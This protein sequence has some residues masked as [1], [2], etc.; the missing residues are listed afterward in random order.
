MR[1]R[2]DQRADSLARTIRLTEEGLRLRLAFLGLTDRERRE[3]ARL[4]PWAERVADSIAKRFYDFQFGFEPTRRFFERYAQARGMPL[5]E[6]RR[7][8]EQ[9]QADYFREIFRAAQQGYDLAY[10]QQRLRIGVRHNLIDLPMKWYLGSYGRYLD[11]VRAEL[12]RSYPLQPW[13][14]WRVERA[15]TKV[16]NLDQQAVV[17]AFFFEYLDSVGFDLAAVVPERPEDDLSDRYRELKEGVLAA[18][19]GLQRVT[20]LAG[21]ASARLDAMSQDLAHAATE[22][23]QAVQVVAGGSV[24]QSELLEQATRAI[25]EV[26]RAVGDIARGAAEQ[27]RAVQRLTEL[28]QTLAAA[29]Q[30]VAT[31]AH[32]GALAAQRNSEEAASGSETVRRA[33]SSLRRSGEAMQQIGTRVTEMATLS[34]RITQMVEAVDEIARQT[35]LLALNAAIEAARA[36]EAGKGFAVV[37]EEV[38]KLAERSSLT[39]QEIRGLV[40]DVLRTLDEVVTVTTS[41]VQEVEE[42]VTLAGSAEMALQRLMTGTREIGERMQAVG[43]ASTTMTRAKDELIAE[44]ERVTRVI[45]SHTAATEEVA[46]TLERVTRQVHEVAAAS[47]DT[48]AA[49]ES[50]GTLVAQLQSETERVR[51]V[52]NTLAD[53]AG[54]LDRV[55]RAFRPLD[56]AGSAYQTAGVN[57]DQ[58]VPVPPR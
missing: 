10:F 36:G 1:T 27:Q 38:R 22:A 19:R 54:Q 18:I 42:G 6:V 51:H 52:A 17:D 46:V 49:A 47:R 33:I 13:R 2:Q 40:D 4:L 30:A 48:S 50:L 20:A 53:A 5:A 28:A 44:L 16:F 45:E 12:R 37:A 55:A 24:R 11:F 43:N 57:D 15:L 23:A 41:G 26:Q 8:L 58:G 32:E 34:R 14:W 21:R 39:T 7:R 31:T 3:L 9:S 25:D 56:D 29:I 35:N